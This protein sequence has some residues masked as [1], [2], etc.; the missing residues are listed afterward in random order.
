MS[1]SDP[2]ITFIRTPAEIDRERLETFARSLVERVT[3]SKPFAC[4]ITGD[5]ELRRLNQNYLGHDYVT[6]VLSFPAGQDDFAGD[7]AI[8]RQRASAQAREFGHDVH[9]EI[10]ILML[11]GVLHLAGLDHETDGGHMRR[12]ETQWRKKFGLPTGL[13]ERSSP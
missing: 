8:S 1:T 11:H 3:G 9:Q 13:I 6:D 5:A 7:I 10:E 2:L 12:V 4:R